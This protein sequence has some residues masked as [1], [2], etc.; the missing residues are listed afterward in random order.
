MKI[1]GLN[2]TFP[3]GLATVVTVGNFDGVHRG[4]ARL[5]ARVTG[6]ARER[7]AASVVVTFEPHT[8]SV[9]FPKLSTK[10]LTT[11]EEKVSLME[12]MGVDYVLRVDFDENFRRMEQEEFIERVLVDKLGAVGWVMGEGHHVGKNLAGVKKKLH[13][14]AGK[15]HIDTSTELLEAADGAAIS[16]TRIRGLV[17]D[18][19]MGEAAAMLG[20]PYLIAAERVAG[21]KIATKLGFPTLNFKRPEAMKVVPPAG[22]YAA[23]IEIDGKVRGFG[24]GV[25]VCG[26]GGGSVGGSGADGGNIGGRGGAGDGGIGEEA[27]GRLI[28]ALYFGDCPTY[29]N[30]ETHFEFHALRYGGVREPAIGEIVRLWLRRY[31]RPNTAFSDESALKAQITLDINEIKQYFLE[32]VL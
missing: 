12:K 2:D 19:R 26:V 3:S 23:E 10:L 6:L 11:F 18:G 30:R 17:S 20:R 28:G 24:G 21:A 1:I 22:V 32:E 15:Y 29:A 27:A 25:D 9:V 13:F 16:S 4:H 14:A 8:R 31:I 5:I 7:G